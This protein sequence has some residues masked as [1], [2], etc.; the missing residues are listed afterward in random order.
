MV[1][2]QRKLNI[3][4]K[5][6]FVVNSTFLLLSHSKTIIFLRI[7]QKIFSFG[8]FI[9]RGWTSYIRQHQWHHRKNSYSLYSGWLPYYN[10]GK[11][12]VY[13]KRITNL[14]QF[15]TRFKTLKIKHIPNNKMYD[16]T[17]DGKN[18]IKCRRARIS[19]L[20]SIQWHRS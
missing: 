10:A 20:P 16:L 12:T 18:L 17:K 11:C 1:N 7:E 5:F 9:E 15:I 14:L 8:I 3:A 6:T 4:H 13:Y 2:V 19:L